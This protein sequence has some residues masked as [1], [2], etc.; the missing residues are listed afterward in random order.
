MLLLL[1]LPFMAIAPS[2]GMPAPAYP[3]E[4]PMHAWMMQ[5]PGMKI[6]EP[7]SEAYC[8]KGKQI[9]KTKWRL[10]AAGTI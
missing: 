5:F 10:T 3:E 7:A 2:G 8:G 1:C 6:E 4:S 9:D